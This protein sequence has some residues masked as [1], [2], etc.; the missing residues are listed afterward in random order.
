MSRQDDTLNSSTI[1]TALT[2]AA[3]SMMTLAAISRYLF[4]QVDV[5]DLKNIPAYRSPTAAK[6][7]AEPGG[8]TGHS[9]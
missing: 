1:F 4:S 7:P 5:E 2:A 9:R 3:V 8:K 6:A